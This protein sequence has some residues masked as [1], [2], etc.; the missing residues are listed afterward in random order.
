VYGFGYSEEF[1][2]EFMRQT[3][4]RPAIATKFAP[5]PWRLT[6][7]SVPAACRASLKRLQLDKME[8]YIQ[9]W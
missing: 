8:L 9:H 1:L 4:T 3:G 7:A 5:L 6:A 2:G